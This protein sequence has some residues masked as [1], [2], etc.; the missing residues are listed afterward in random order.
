MQAGV[1]GE[2]DYFST[3]RFTVPAGGEGYY[4]VGASSQ[5]SI[6]G[7][8]AGAYEF[9]VAQ[10]GVELFGEL[11]GAMQSA[12]FSNVVTLAAGDTIDLL[13]GRGTNATAS[14]AEPL[15]NAVISLISSNN[16]SGPP[17]MVTAPQSQAVNLGQVVTL[18]V[19][20]TGSSPFTY[21]WYAGAAGDLNNPIPGATN[22][23]F[24]PGGVYATESFWVAVQNPEGGVNSAAAVLTVIPESQAKLGLQII[25][26][27]PF[28]TITGLEGTS[29]RIEYSTNLAT[30]NWTTLIQVTLPSATFTFSDSGA[31]NPARYYRAVTP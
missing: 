12:S 27:L 5:P 14:G 23:T 22:A 30:T 7:S 11:L 8:E 4:S 9:H 17:V 21:Q 25:G 15:V 3:I 20:V 16:A 18:S 28:L 2:P 31:T 24:S 29:Y 26:G 19:V 13:V 6:V 10:N 1:P